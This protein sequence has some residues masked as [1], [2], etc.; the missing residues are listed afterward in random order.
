M[1]RPK[2]F[3]PPLKQH[4]RL[5]A[6]ERLHGALLD[7]H[8]KG[9]SLGKQRDGGGGGQRVRGMRVG[10]GRGCEDAY[11]AQW[12]SAQGGGQG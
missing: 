8:N 1:T 10:M 2:L 7:L 9:V 11:R 3:Q 12:G 4:K 5:P 6:T